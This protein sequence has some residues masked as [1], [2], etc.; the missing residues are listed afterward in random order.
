LRKNQAMAEIGKERWAQYK[1]N[2]LLILNQ[3]SSGLYWKELFAEL[4]KVMPPNE[5]ENSGYESNGQRRRPYI[6][7]FS[8]IA[9]VKAGWLVKNKG[10]WS[11]TEE[12]KLALAKFPTAEALQAQSQ[13]LYNE[14]RSGQPDE[15]EGDVQDRE[16]ELVASIEEAEDNAMSII[17]QYLGSMDP[18]RFQDLIGALLEGMG[19]HVS[20]IAPPGK[21]GGMD[22]IA[23]QDPLGATGRRIKVQV[24]RRADKAGAESL[25]SFLGVLSEDDIGLYICTGGFSSD[26]ER[27]AREQE[28]KRLTL[29]DSKALF[30]LWVEYYEHLPQASRALMPLKPIYHLDLPK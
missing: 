4:D 13:T 15:D 7:R 23:F 17:T 3:H 6:V 21:D 10:H 12:G 18:Y 30:L 8:T 24:K 20:W 16:I 11:I 19:Y 2:V 1:Q 5:F 22:I 26:A 25:R 14:W 28:N 27:T 9:L 29:L